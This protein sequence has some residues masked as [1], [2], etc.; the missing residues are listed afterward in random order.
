LLLGIVYALAI[1]VPTPSVEDTIIGFFIFN[2]D[3]LKID[4]KLPIL[5]K[6]PTP[7]FFCKF[8]LIF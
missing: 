8:S 7:M 1:L 3:K 6:A 4:P 2:L 5:E